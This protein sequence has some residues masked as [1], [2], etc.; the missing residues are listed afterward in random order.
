VIRPGERPLHALRERGVEY[1]EVRLMDLDPFVPVGIKAQTMRF[2]D[3]FLL[4]CLLADSPDD[5][6]QEIARSAATSTAPPPSAASRP[7]LERDGREVKLTDW[8]ARSSPSAAHRPRAG[9]RARHH[10]LRRRGALRRALLQTTRHAA[11]GARAG[12]HGARPRNSFAG[13]HA[14]AVGADQGQAAEAA[15]PAAQARWKRSW[16]AVAAGPAASRRAT[17]CRSSTTASST[18][19]PSGWA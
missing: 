10:R 18:S 19:R 16:R 5:T 4:H 2:L 13:V 3:V 9:R 8:G 15:V 14:G 11:V 12:R 1:V 7:A 6:P 17:P